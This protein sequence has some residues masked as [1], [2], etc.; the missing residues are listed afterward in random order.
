MSVLKFSNLIWKKFRNSKPKIKSVLTG[1]VNP[2]K[3]FG[4]KKSINIDKICYTFD[5]LKY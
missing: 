2:I 5:K 3:N 4:I 1:K